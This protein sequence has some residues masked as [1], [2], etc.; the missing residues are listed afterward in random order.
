MSN[1]KAQ[2]TNEK[3]KGKRENV[4]AQRTNQKPRGKG[5]K[6]MPKNTGKQLG[7]I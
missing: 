2:M 6:D 4:K 3:A 7:E 5:Q 1:I